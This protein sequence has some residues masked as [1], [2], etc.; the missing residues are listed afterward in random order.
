M[1]DLLSR[2]RG[3]MVELVNQVSW[4]VDQMPSSPQVIARKFCTMHDMTHLLLPRPPEIPPLSIRRLPRIRLPPSLEPITRL[5]RINLDIRPLS[6]PSNLPVR[7]TVLISRP[8]L[9][10]LLGFSLAL[11]NDLSTFLPR[12]LTNRTRPSRISLQTS[13]L[14]RHEIALRLDLCLAHFVR[15]HAESSSAHGV[16]RLW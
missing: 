4:I 1:A 5:E 16:Q 9:H 2:K 6:R 3:L 12:R 13:L 14:S 7:H 8:K 10:L 11:D 15:Q